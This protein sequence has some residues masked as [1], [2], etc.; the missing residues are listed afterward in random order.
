VSGLSYMTS[1]GESGVTGSDG[2]FQY[3]TG[4]TIIFSISGI[5]L[6]TAVAQN[7]ITPVNLASASAVSDPGV[8]NMTRFLMMLDVETSPRGVR[9]RPTIWP[10][11]HLCIHSIVDH[12]VRNKM[13]RTKC[14]RR[15]S[16][17]K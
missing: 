2:S 12:F 15:A 14:A 11:R 17:R 13:G 3:Q 9:S 6:G 1:T 16:D 5:T 8:V 7:I 4:A 10:Q